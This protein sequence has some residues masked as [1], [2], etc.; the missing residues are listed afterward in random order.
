[1]AFPDLTALLIAYI[2]PLVAPTAVASRIPDPRPVGF[3][4]VRRVGGTARPPVRE[5]ARFDVFCW[6]AGEPAA[7]STAST[8]RSAVWALAGTSLLGIP[9]Y[10]VAELLGPRLD[11]DDL[12]GTPRVWATYE[13]TTRADDVMHI[14]PSISSP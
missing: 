3:V 1:M 10:E 8:I 14:A 2:A 12:T 6:A 11:D 13:L 9:T 7:Q 4:Q 5:R